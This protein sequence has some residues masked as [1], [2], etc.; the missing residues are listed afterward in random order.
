MKRSKIALMLEVHVLIEN[1]Q[2]LGENLLRDAPGE[3]VFSQ[4]E[5]R[6]MRMGIF[7]ASCFPGCGRIAAP[8]EKFPPGI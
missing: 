6:I 3:E 1:R 7:L 4:S 8:G 2:S 5:R